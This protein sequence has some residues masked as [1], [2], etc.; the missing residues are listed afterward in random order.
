MGDGDL[1]TFINPQHSLGQGA[2]VDP[3]WVGQRVGNSS[4][5]S[6]KPMWAQEKPGSQIQILKIPGLLR[7]LPSVPKYGTDHILRL[8]ITSFCWSESVPNICN[9][10][11]RLITDIVLFLKEE[12]KSQFHGQQNPQC[13]VLSCSPRKRKIYHISNSIC[14]TEC[15]AP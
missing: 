15:Q 8:K 7:S 6:N 1:M 2:G 3:L 9:Q 5:Y 12:M 11:D 13:V 10:E 4:R 14:Q